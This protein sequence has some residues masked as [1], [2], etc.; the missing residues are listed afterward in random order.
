MPFASLASTS[1]GRVGSRKYSANMTRQP[2][3]IWGGWRTRMTP[4]FR[5]RGSISRTS[6]APCNR[7][8][9]CS[10]IH[11]PSFPTP[12]QRLDLQ[13][14]DGFDLGRL[15]EHVQGGDGDDREPALQLRDV[16]CER[17]RIAGNVDHC[18]RRRI[19]N[20]A[21]HFGGETGGGRIKDQG[22]RSEVALLQ[23]PT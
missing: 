10:P 8:P 5:S 2:S 9:R 19:E 4:T 17:R 15:G 23:E 1:G 21:A 22:R 20:G 12:L 14:G 18:G 7:T 3:A 6:S 11:P 16:A 13:V